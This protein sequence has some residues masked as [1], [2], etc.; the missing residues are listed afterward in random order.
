MQR[1]RRTLALL[2][3]A[4]ALLS[5]CIGLIIDYGLKARDIERRRVHKAIHIG[6]HLDEIRPIIPEQVF[7][8]RKVGLWDDPNRELQAAISRFC[9]LD[10]PCLS[11]PPLPANE[12]RNWQDFTVVQAYFHPATLGDAQEQI[13]FLLFDRKTQLLVAKVAPDAEDLNPAP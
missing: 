9:P 3:A 10:N 11:D 13:L 5:G 6:M 2:L 4:P 12:T 8:T 7:V 1:T